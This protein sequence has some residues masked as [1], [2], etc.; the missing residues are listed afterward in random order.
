MV[1][2]LPLLGLGFNLNKVE[3]E[4][5]KR[6]LER[7]GY[8]VKELK[9]NQENIFQVKSLYED[10]AKMAI[11]VNFNQTKEEQVDAWLSGEDNKCS[12]GKD[13]GHISPLSRIWN[14]LEGAAKTIVGSIRT[15]SSDP[16]KLTKFV[17][18]AAVMAGL[19][20]FGGPIGAA[21]ATTAGLI[22]ACGL[23][24]N[25]IKDFI[26]ANKIANQAQTDAEAKAA[27]EQMG[28]GTLQVGIGIYC[29]GKVLDSIPSGSIKPTKPPVFEDEFI[30]NL[31]DV[32]VLADNS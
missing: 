22:G 28:S 18:T 17:G 11:G 31:K 29:G 1:L 2:S 4:G 8:D 23:I 13:D 32:S 21:I 3:F 24:A 25:G 26:V 19:V 12:D 6:T 9:C 15:L 27:F 30:E 16:V 14:F 10:V 5:R 20:A 7:L